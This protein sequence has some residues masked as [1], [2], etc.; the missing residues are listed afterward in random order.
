MKACKKSLVVLL[1]MLLSAC[2]LAACSP[3]D[4]KSTTE[5]EYTLIDN[6]YY[7]VSGIGTCTDTKI[8]IPAEYSGLPVKSIGDYAFS[9]CKEL[10][11]ITIPDS[12][13]SIG[14]AAFLG[15]H[16]LTSIALPQSVINI[17]DSAFSVCSKLTSITVPDRVTSIGENAFSGCNGLTD[18]TIPKSVTNIGEQAFWYCSNLKIITFTGTQTEWNAVKKD[19][20]WKYSCPADVVCIGTEAPE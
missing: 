20:S 12:I 15:C 16:N 5:L 9:G 19:D 10:T 4:T 3:A 11:D 14:E 13:T 7:A 17:G 8:D 6:S 2:N 1:A 18:I